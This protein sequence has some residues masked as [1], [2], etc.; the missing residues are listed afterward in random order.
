MLVPVLLGVSLNLALAKAERS[1]GPVALWASALGAGE[2]RDAYDYA[3]QRLSVT[4]GWVVVELVGHT[5]EAPRLIGGRYGDRSAVG[6]TPSAHDL[7]LEQL[8]FVHERA[9][10]LRELIGQTEPARGVYIA[11]SQ[12]ARFEVLP[13]DAGD[14]IEE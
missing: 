8:C 10:G 1:D 12:I 5:P 6:Q 4:G 9:D 11:A 7:Y 3:W 2:A 14:T 13:L